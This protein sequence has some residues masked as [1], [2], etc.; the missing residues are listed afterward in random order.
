MTA[1]YTL[2]ESS[3]V[4][5]FRDDLIGHVIH[6]LFMEETDRAIMERAKPPQILPYKKI[7]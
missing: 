5:I 7:H 2:M 3:S 1:K 6:D 4:L